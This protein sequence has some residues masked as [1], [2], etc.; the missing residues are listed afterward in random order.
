MFL[1]VQDLLWPGLG[2]IWQN[3]K[4][5]HSADMQSE[6]TLV[7]DLQPCQLLLRLFQKALLA[8]RR[9]DGCKRLLSATLQTA[10]ALSPEGHAQLV[11]KVMSASDEVR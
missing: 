9:A 5:L 1:A 2:N 8:V 4:C 7:M 10:P 3:C 6:P 11:Q